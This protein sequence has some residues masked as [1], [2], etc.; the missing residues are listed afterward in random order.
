[1]RQFSK[2]TSV[3]RKKRL[4][5]YIEED[6]DDEIADIVKNSEDTN[7]KNDFDFIEEQLEFEKDFNIVSNMLSDQLLTYKEAEI[8]AIIELRDYYTD[9]N[10][11]I[12]YKIDLWL[13]KEE[14][15]LQI[16][17]YNDDY[18]KFPDYDPENT[19]LDSYNDDYS[20]FP[21]YDPEDTSLDFENYDDIENPKKNENT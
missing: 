5:K 17:S 10:V 21:D 7:T 11:P 19:S 14:N 13:K 18:S 16:D 6:L 9:N 2:Q 15:R 3:S 12:D 20:K 1:M 8:K 4:Q